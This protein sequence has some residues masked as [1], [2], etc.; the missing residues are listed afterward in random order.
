MRITA[1]LLVALLGAACAEEDAF[2]TP[3]G[4]NGRSCAT[5]HAAE[6]GWSVTPVQIQ[7]LFAQTGAPT[8]SSTRSTPTTPT[9]TSRRWRRAARPTHVAARIVPRGGTIPAG[10]EFEVVA[11]DDPHGVGTT[12]RL[13][14]YRRPLTTANLGLHREHV[15]RSP[16]RSRGRRRQRR[17]ARPGQLARGIIVGVQEGAPPS[18]ATVNAIVDEELAIWY[19]QSEARGV[20]LDSCG[21]KGGP[22]ALAAQGLVVGRF[23]LYDAGIDLEPGS[24][25]TRADDE[26]RAGIA[27]GQQLFDERRS[28]SG[29]RCVGC[30]SAANAAPTPAA[31]SS[32]PARRI[33]RIA[34]PT[35]RSTRCATWRPASCARRRIPARAW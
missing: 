4:A 30:H 32:T 35:C 14:F 15:G 34:P 16:E 18:D 2:H 6:A 20:R 8:P 17:A 24:C 11:A 28:A 1:L 33:R 3:Q 13:S 31:S 12:Q 10:A 9:P 22:R 5:C 7:L 29:A 21:G 25:S 26:Q 27:R 19:A 23:D